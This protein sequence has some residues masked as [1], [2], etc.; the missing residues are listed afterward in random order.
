MLHIRIILGTGPIFTI[1]SI[2]MLRESV[3]SELY[4]HKR[5]AYSELAGLCCHLLVTLGVL[6]KGQSDELFSV[7]HYHYETL[8]IYQNLE[9]KIVISILEFY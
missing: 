1:N 8:E 5:Q 2:Y 9:Y 3:L 4:H 7:F 6:N